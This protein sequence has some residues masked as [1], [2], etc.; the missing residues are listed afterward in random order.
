MICMAAN[1]LEAP[2][3]HFLDAAEGWLELGLPQE[4]TTELK[5][6][7]PQL[8]LHP[9]VLELSWRI[10]ARGKNWEAALNVAHAMTKVAGDRPDGWIYLSFALHELGRTRDALEILLAVAERFPGI[11]AISYNIA[12][13]ACQL[14]LVPEAEKW[15]KN[16][17][18]HGNRLELKL[19]AADDP[20]LEP[21][22]HKLAEI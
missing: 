19:M 22:W 13:Y 7:S 9:E 5:E 21:L 1:R 4:A 6:I 10:Y 2:D 11:S 3:R 12:C 16:A 8:R 20:D 14:G 18:S 17:F 15:L